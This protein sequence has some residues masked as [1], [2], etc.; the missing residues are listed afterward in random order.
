MMIKICVGSSCH[1][2]GSAQVIEAFRQAVAERPESEQNEIQLGGSFCMGECQKGVNVSI[3]GVIY[4][5]VTPEQV[6]QIMELRK[7]G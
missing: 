4:H 6:P 5:Q 1:I 2:K 3:D 7:D